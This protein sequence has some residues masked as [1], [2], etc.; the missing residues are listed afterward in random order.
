MIE[1]HDVIPGTR[2]NQVAGTDAIGGGSSEDRT[3]NGSS[4]PSEHAGACN[5]APAH[6]DLGQSMPHDR[7]ASSTGPSCSSPESII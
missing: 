5:G 2:T 3:V 1:A 6:L 7:G 4:A